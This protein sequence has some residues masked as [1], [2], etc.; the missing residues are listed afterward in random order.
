MKHAALKRFVEYRILLPMV[1][2]YILIR[3]AIKGFMEWP[4]EAKEFFLGFTV[5]IISLLGLCGLGTGVRGV[6]LEVTP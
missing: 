2:I 5:A 3:Q 6:R 1:L 4:A